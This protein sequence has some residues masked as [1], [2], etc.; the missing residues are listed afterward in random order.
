MRSRNK[1]RSCKRTLW[2]TIKQLKEVLWPKTQEIE[3]EKLH[4]RNC[5]KACMASI[6]ANMMRF[7]FISG[8]ADWQINMKTADKLVG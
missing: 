4:E 3:Q 7:R 8:T 6:V 2:G 1:V 5:L